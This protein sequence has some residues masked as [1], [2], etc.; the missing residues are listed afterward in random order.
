MKNN[1]K[2]VALFVHDGPLYKDK[3]GVYCSTNITEEM[4]SRYFCVA[5]EIHVLIRTYQIDKTYKDANLQKID[6]PKIRVIELG[7]IVSI[8]GLLQKNKLKKKLEPIV[9]ECNL[10]FLRLPG[11]TCNVVAD[12]CKEQNKKYL[13]EVGGCAWDA[14]WNHGILGKIVAP[15]MEHAEK[16]TTRNASFATYVT[17]KWLQNRYPCFCENIE[18]SNVYL[19]EQ[20]E[21]VIEKRLKRIDSYKDCKDL[22]IGTIANVDVRYKGQ[23]YIIKAIAKLNKKGYNFKYELV[24]GG[25]QTFLKKIAVKYGVE[26]N[27]FF[28]GALLHNDVIKWLDGIDIYAQPSKQEG[29]PRSVIEA[30]SRGVPCIGSNVAGI[31]ELIDENMIFPCGNTNQIAKII[32]NFDKK[33]LATSSIQNFEMAKGFILDKLEKKRNIIYRKYFMD[34]INHGK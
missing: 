19:P 20:D 27:V 15:Y 1:Q 16:K 26:K 23:E 25:D 24:G 18:A 31:P 14:Y 34:S 3:D 5:D 12:I 32:F 22:T 13:V 4:L 10:V 11:I 30:M 29:L 7:N 2:T 9:N 33:T 21:K 6:N 28:R 17:Q 8:K